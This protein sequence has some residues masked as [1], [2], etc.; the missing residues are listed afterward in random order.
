MLNKFSIRSLLIAMIL[1]SMILV[2]AVS[3]S[4]NNENAVKMNISDNFSAEKIS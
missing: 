3:A 1:I 2:S 4:D